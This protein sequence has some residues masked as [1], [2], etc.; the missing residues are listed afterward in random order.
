[1]LAA[2]RTQADC[3]VTL[4]CGARM[5]PARAFPE[6]FWF[7]GLRPPPRTSLRVFV[8]CVPCAC[9]RTAVLRPH[10]ILPLA[11][12]AIAVVSTRWLAE[13]TV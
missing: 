8:L 1:M 12:T 11:G 3:A 2:T 5:V 7:H 9:A 6:P 13:P 10:M 4:T